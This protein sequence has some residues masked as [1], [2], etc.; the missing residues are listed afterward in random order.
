[1]LVIIG[2]FI[3]FLASVTKDYQESYLA[4]YSKIN[5]KT[6]NDYKTVSIDELSDFT[7]EYVLKIKSSTQP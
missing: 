1:M 6:M 4:E 5:Q 2:I 7:K 3:G